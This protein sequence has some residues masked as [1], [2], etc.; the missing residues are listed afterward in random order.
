MPIIKSAKKKMR[1]DVKRH[2]V[3]LRAKN[4]MKKALHLT[5]KSPTVKNVQKAFHDIDMALKKGLIHKN[6]A[7]RLKSR[8]AKKQNKNLKK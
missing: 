7:A 6:T 1:Q 8:L 2:L 3:N 5:R 4:A